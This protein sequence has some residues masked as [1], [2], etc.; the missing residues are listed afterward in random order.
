MLTTTKGANCLY[1]SVEKWHLDVVKALME[2]GG[3]KL[4]MLSKDDGKAAYTTMLRIG[5]WMW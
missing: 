5:I 2:A 4:L 1:G 3:R